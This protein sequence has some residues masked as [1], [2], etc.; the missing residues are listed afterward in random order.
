MVIVSHYSIRAIVC[1]AQ[2]K[3]EKTAIVSE[4]EKPRH[5]VYVI[6]ICGMAPEGR[7]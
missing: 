2:I 6:S 5:N 7:S 4:A 3:D 1:I